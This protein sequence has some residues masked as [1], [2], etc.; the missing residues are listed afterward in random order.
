[1]HI[2][3]QQLGKESKKNITMTSVDLQTPAQFMVVIGPVNL[4]RELV[5]GP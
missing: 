3:K 2:G 5:V 4:I 1:M